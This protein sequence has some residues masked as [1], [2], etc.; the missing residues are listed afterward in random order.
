MITCPAEDLSL[1]NDQGTDESYKNLLCINIKEDEDM[2]LSN[3]WFKKKY[4]NY[5]VSLDRCIDLPGAP[6]FCETA[7]QIKSYMQDN[8]F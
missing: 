3:N 6:K 8:F 5:F 7:E 1:F 2:V 4:T